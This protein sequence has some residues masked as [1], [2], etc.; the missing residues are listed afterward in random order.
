MSVRAAVMDDEGL[1]RKLWGEFIVEH[2]KS[3][4][5]IMPTARTMNFFMVLFRE[6][7]SGHDSGAVV[8]DTDGR[9]VL[10]WGESSGGLPYDSTF[11]RVASG[12]GT[13]VQPQH[14]GK[15]ISKALR[16]KGTKLLKKRGFDT[17]IG[18]AASANEVG[19]ETGIRFGFEPYQLTGALRL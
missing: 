12:W 9:G 5:D 18:A 17:V 1:F 8:L 11:G 10:M 19:K 4:S 16:R 7:T 15:G 13:Y 2:H 14:Q 3:G 6:Y